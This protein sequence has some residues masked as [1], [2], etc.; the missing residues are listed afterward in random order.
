MPLWI[1]MMR[2]NFTKKSGGV[3]FIDCFFEDT[4]NRPFIVASEKKNDYGLFDVTGE[5]TVKNP[6]GAFMNLGTKTPDVTLE[7]VSLKNND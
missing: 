2:P 4:R 3:D 6:Y 7:V 1:Q 5:I